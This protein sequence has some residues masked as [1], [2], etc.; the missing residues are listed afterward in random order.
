M[1][2]FEYIAPATVEEAVAQLGAG[3]RALAGGTDLIVQMREGRRQVGRVVDLKRIAELNQVAAMPDGGVAIGAA[4]NVTALAAHPAM[5]VYPALVESGRMIGSYQIQNRASIGGN[6]CNAAPSADAVPALICLDARAVV[7]GPG[8]RRD[9]PVQALF[10]GPGRTTL[11]PQDILVSLRLPAPAERS[12]A[13]YLRFTPRREMDIAVAGVGAWLRLDAKGAVAEARVALAAVGPTPIRAAQA[14]RRMIGEKP[15]A[16]LV[17][18]AAAL[19]VRD[20]RP[21]SDTRG[22]AEYRRELVNTLAARA[23]AMCLARLGKPLETP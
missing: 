14:E 13:A 6:V 2:E 7:A 1:N 20:A 22:S 17:A 19:A 5:A 16:K 11:G 3:A 4:L 21:I 10:A 18:E 8:G 9:E 15:S 23:V 12:A